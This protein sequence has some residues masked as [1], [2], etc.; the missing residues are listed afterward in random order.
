M[1]YNTIGEFDHLTLFLIDSILTCISILREYLLVLLVLVTVV[2]VLYSVDAASAQQWCP[3]PPR[4][5]QD[6]DF[7]WRL[8]THEWSNNVTAP[9]FLLFVLSWWVSLRWLVSGHCFLSQDTNLLR[10]AGSHCT[11][12]RISMFQWQP[13]RSR[14]AWSMASSVQSSVCSRSS[15]KLS[16]RESTEHHHGQ[17]ILLHVTRRRSDSKSMGEARSVCS[18]NILFVSS[19]LGYRYLLL[20]IGCW[21]LCHHR[22]IV[23]VVE[24][25]RDSIDEES[26]WREYQKCA[27]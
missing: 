2:A 15:A 22:E 6:F 4:F 5:K 23:S 27:D 24:T 17:T 11:W 12:S 16:R 7:K 3:L 26:N 25:A 10:L 13:F 14:R 18:L 21:I 8:R 9:D 20:P 1:L 19:E